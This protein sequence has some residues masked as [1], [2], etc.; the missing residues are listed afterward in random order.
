MPIEHQR[1]PF[2]ATCDLSVEIVA[3]RSHLAHIDLEPDL[4]HHRL[5]ESAYLGLC[6]SDAEHVDQVVCP[7]GDPL[8]V[9]RRHHFLCLHIFT[10]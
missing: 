8:G 2:T 7:F 6:H 3:P 4:A 1:R 5:I 10:L 9:Y